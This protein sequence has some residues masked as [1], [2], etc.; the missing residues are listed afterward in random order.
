MELAR[1]GGQRGWH[2]K[3]TAQIL[4]I[5]WFHGPFHRLLYGEEHEAVLTDDA[6]AEREIRGACGVILLRRK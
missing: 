2:C 3:V 5:G 4:V 6:V 1:T